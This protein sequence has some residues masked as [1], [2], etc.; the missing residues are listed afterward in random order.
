MKKIIKNKY[1]IIAFCII[2]T[3]IIYL[4]LKKTSDNEN[5]IYTED[6]IEQNS[7]DKKIIYTDEEIDLEMD[8]YNGT[9]EEEIQEEGET[10]SEV[11]NTKNTGNEKSKI[12]I[13]ITGEVNNPG[14][15]TLDE[16]SRIVDAINAAGGTT[17]NADI[18]KINLVY[19]LEDGMKI[20]IP[21]KSELKEN[22]NYEYI[23]KGS[24]EGKVDEND[25]S[26]YKN[27]TSKSSNSVKYSIVNINSATQTELESLPGIGPSLAL[28][29]IN[30]RKENGKFS[31]IEEIKEV[32]GIGE[33]KYNELKKY[34]TI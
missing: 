9:E 25:S 2:I 17:S 18:S 23:T 14:V 12:Y 13:H 15:V 29:I 28:R 19:I 32:S 20:N 4:S 26:D 10:E 6:E 33:A 3:G 1:I 7:D 34:I 27:E 31:S 11:D 24:G 22:I 5:I 8:E 16:G 21:D 30:Y